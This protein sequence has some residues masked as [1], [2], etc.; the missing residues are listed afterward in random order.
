MATKIS[1][2]REEIARLER[3]VSMTETALAL[4][5]M[6]KP[7]ARETVRENDGAKYVLSLYGATR[8]DGGVVV[9]RFVCNGQRDSFAVSYL[10]E[11]FQRT[12]GTDLGWKFRTACDLFAIVRQRMLDAETV[13]AS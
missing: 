12:P 13:G 7:D 11:W 6:G 1:E 9:T 4:S 10:D 3:K 8:W 5:L 2:L